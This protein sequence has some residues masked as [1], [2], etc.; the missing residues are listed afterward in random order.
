MHFLS[1][2]CGVYA[3]RLE[4]PTHS[5]VSFDLN[6]HK[7]RFPVM[8]T[9]GP[10]CLLGADFLRTFKGLLSMQH[11][12]IQFTLP[13]GA[14]TVVDCDGSAPCNEAR[15]LVKVIRG[16]LRGGESGGDRYRGFCSGRGPNGGIRSHRFPPGL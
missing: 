11:S 7:V 16:N 1:A 2:A 5:S 14:C 15:R 6:G 4:T 9:E 3:L 10:D 13:D 8:V 12:A